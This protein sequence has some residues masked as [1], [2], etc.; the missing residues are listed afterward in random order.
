MYK[1]EDLMRFLSSFSF[2][3]KLLSFFSLKE[4]LNSTKGITECIASF[5]SFHRSPYPSR[6]PIRYLLPCIPPIH[7]HNCCIIL[8]TERRYPISTA[9]FFL[10]LFFSFLFCSVLFFSF[11]PVRYFPLS[12]SFFFFFSF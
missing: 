3:Q 4:G 10:F 12:F 5:F 11:V 8:H 2:N 1:W 9:I 7:Q 6:Q